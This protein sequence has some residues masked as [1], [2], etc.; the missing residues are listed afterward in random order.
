MST[1][2]P[3]RSNACWFAVVPVLAAACLA[4]GCGGGSHVTTPAN[5]NSPSNPSTPSTPAAFSVSAIVP[6][7]GATQVPLSATIQ[8]TFSAAAN[9][10]TVSTTNI[11]LTDPKPVAG[12]VAY[13]ASNNTATFTPS[14]ALVP[15]S[16]YTVTVSGVTSANGTAMASAFVS[17]FATVSQSASGGGG[18]GSGNGGGSS[19]PTL[20]YQ[21]TLENDGNFGQISMDTTGKT[22]VQLTGAVANVKFTVEFCPAFNTGGNGPNC[23]NVGTVTSDANGSANA[24]MMFPKPGS[25]SGDFQLTSSYVVAPGTTAGYSTD[26]EGN[27]PN[28]VYMSTLQPINTVN[29]GTLS[30]N[31]PQAQLTSGSVTYSNGSSPKQGSLQFVLTG[32]PPDTTF[33]VTENAGGLGGSDSYLLYNSQGQSAFTTDGKGN[34]TFTVLS[35]G[36]FGDTF[37]VSAQSTYAGYLGGFSVP[38]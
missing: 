35:D 32:A 23:F 20:Q 29:G 36:A 24:S 11:Q 38:N 37:Q 1:K 22:T 7:A 5:P 34:L 33:T 25:W 9:A 28:Q 26:V 2:L 30:T 27:D 16:T 19:S 6:A 15:N 21:A 17:N 14:A 10:S 8:I 31:A 12:T 13:N 4:A 18:G 3:A